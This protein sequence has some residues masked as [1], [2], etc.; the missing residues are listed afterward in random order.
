MLFKRHN[1]Y[2]SEVV[3]RYPE[4]FIGLGC[5]DPFSDGAALRKRTAAF[6]KGGLSGIGELA[7]YQSGIENASL[8]RLKPV[9]EICR[10][11]ESSRFNSYQ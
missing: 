8:A 6:K 11:L 1:D 2:I 9:M 7:F 10:D 3:R 5:F 4:R